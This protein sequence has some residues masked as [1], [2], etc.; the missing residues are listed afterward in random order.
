[1]TILNVVLVVA[2]TLLGLLLLLW[3][4]VRVVLPWWLRRKFGA[5]ADLPQGGGLAA[6][7]T[8][9]P[10]EASWQQPQ[11]DAMIGQMLTA[12]FAEA[13]RYAVPQ[14]PGM[15]LWAGTHPQDG[16]AAVI[17]DH[18]SLPPFYDLV[19]VYAH[20][21]SCT[22]STNP[23]HD[24][25]NVPPGN[26]V[27]A[28]PTLSPG[29]ALT[30][31]RDQPE[32]GI[33]M[34]LD[35]ANFAPVF[36]ELYARS[37][38]H[39]LARGMPDAEQMRRVGERMAE[40]TGEPMPAL[41]DAQMAMAVRMQRATRVQALQQA[42]I[43]R[44]LESGQIDAREWERLRDGVIVVHELLEPSEAADLARSGA[45]WERTEALVGQVLAEGLSALDTFEKIVAALPAPQRPRLLG[46]VDHPLYAQVLAMPG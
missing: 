22:V 46:E 26:V 41:D 1:M 2:A 36:I 7:I 20:Q 12:G 9:A 21:A 45:D 24:P 43:D 19:R 29:A 25:Q 5:M 13:G 11:V 28:D 42:V 38:D 6:R 40:V 10:I 31:L 39:M 15:Q 34:P 37:M 14:M 33:C 17:Y 27:L 18:P 35:A 23:I 44:F 3:L 4:L 32:A 16:V 8:L 30:V